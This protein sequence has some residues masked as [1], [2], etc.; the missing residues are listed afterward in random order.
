MSPSP[1]LA[2]T[3]TLEEIPVNSGMPKRVGDSILGL[4]VGFPPSGLR[5]LASFVWVVRGRETRPHYLLQF[6]NRTHVGAYMFPHS[7]ALVKAGRAVVVLVCKCWWAVRPTRLTMSS[8]SIVLCS[9]TALHN[10][11][12]SE[13]L[14]SSRMFLG[15]LCAEREFIFRPYL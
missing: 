11:K 1:E 14:W 10:N 13:D 3:P 8:G 2:G 5:F 15:L 9:Y 12:F 7:Q 4:R 6:Q